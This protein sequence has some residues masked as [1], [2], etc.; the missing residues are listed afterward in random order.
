[1]TES[2][3]AL[4]EQKGCLPQLQSSSESSR[5]L[6]DARSGSPGSLHWP[7]CTHIVC[8]F[9]CLN[10]FMKQWAVGTGQHAHYSSVAKQ[11]IH[12][13]IQHCAMQTRGLPKRRV[14]H[15]A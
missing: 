8:A 14:S 4:R 7:A 15:S 10:S 11:R 1:M 3:T 6:V 2:R 9:A 12:C 13:V 5:P